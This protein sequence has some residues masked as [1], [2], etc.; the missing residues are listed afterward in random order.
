MIRKI[1]IGLGGFIALAAVLLVLGYLFTNPQALPDD[2]SSSEWLQPGPYS[3]GVLETVFVDSSR[4]TSENNGVPGTPTRSFPTHIWYPQGTESAHPLI[5]HSHG[6]VSSRTDLSYATE[7]LASYGYVVV[8]ADYPL[9]SGAAP[10]GPNANDLINQV[11]DV[12][13]LI[14]SVLNLDGADKPF[15]GNIDPERIGLMGYSLGGLTTS[16]ATYHPRLRDDRIKAAVS[17]AGLS[18]ALMPDFYSTS[19]IP[20]LMIGGT[21][22]ALVDYQA[23]AAVIPERVGNSALLTIDG[24]SHLG[25]ASMA[26]PLLR[27]MNHPDGLGCTAVLSNLGE[28]PNAPYLLLGGEAD[29]IVLDP[30]IPA[31]CQTMPE[32]QALHPGRQHMVTQIALLSFF[33]S[34]FAEQATDREWALNQLRDATAAEIS[35]ASYRR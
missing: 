29:G 6:F 31:V 7:H 13:F 11:S 2:S 17:I 28:D 23:N 34:V 33:E 27:F 20:F 4:P 14:D 8:A 26:E 22:D 12:S 15:D 18:A 32:E 19:D 1:A 3:V 24:G 30:T 21:L 16:L 35:E 10:G 9:T 5:L 25:F